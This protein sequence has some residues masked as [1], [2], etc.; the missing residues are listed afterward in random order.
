VAP[1]PGEA[2]P[3]PPAEPA[4]PAAP[5]P[6]A[7]DIVKGITEAIAKG[8]T[9]PVADAAP[10]AEAPPAIY[11]PDEQQ[12]IV[13][14]EKNWPD[15]AQAEALKRKGE[16]HDLTAYIFQEVHKFYAPHLQ[17]M[18]AMGNT[19]HTQELAG[20]VQDY[21]PAV[22]ADVVKWIDTQPAYLQAPM[23]Q[24]MQTGTSEEV[25]DL[26]GRYRGATGTTPAAAA[27]AA[28][29]AAAPAAP[30]TPAKTELSPLAKQAAESLAPVSSDRTQVPAGEDSGDYDS[31]FSRYAAE[32]AKSP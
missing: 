31:A 7:E 9:P 28:P 2:P 13:D 26:I 19:L 4:A 5:A 16:Y 27:P 24:V 17:M 10:A 25:A 20:M 1:T 21:T 12:T 29:A 11:S 32:E 30:A 23:K 22:E 6:S 18:A 15:V 8:V 3:A 14:Y